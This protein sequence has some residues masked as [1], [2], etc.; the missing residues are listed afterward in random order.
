MQVNVVH[1]LAA[2]LVTVEYQT[3]AV[4]GDALIFCDSCFA[5]LTI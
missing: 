2:L 1:R 4:V 3:V 5:V